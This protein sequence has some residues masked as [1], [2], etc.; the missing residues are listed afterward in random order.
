MPILYL[1]LRSPHPLRDMP[2]VSPYKLPMGDVGS[3][4]YTYLWVRAFNVPPSGMIQK[5][6]NLIGNSIGECISVDAEEDGRCLG[7]YI[8]IRVKFDISKPL[9]RV[10]KLTLDPGNPPVGIVLRYKKV[11]DY[12]YICGKFGHQFKQCSLFD[13]E[14]EL[15]VRN[16]PYGL[17]LRAEEEKVFCPL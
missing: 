11:P 16:H 9:K 4:K 13:R 7:L 17:W 8:R 5:V 2:S 15:N 1:E 12:C 3:F 10:V 14:M 6:G